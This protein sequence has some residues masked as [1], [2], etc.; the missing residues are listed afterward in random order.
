VDFVLKGPI[1]NECS[2]LVSS[3]ESDKSGLICWFSYFS[4]C[5]NFLYF[6]F[7]QNFEKKQTFS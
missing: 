1:Y 2:W 6:C 3:F 5:R 7:Y 4:N